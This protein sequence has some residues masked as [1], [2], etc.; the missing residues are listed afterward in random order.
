MVKEPIDLNTIRRKIMKYK[1]H[2]EF[3]ADMRRVPAC[4]IHVYA[5][6]LH[7]HVYTHACARVCTDMSVRMSVD[8]PAHTSV[9]MPT[10]MSAHMHRTLPPCMRTRSES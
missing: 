4:S 5:A 6:C 8:M 7:T 10:H 3:A 9:H 2:A 1:A